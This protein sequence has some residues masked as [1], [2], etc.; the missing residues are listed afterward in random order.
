MSFVCAKETQNIKINYN[1]IFTCNKGI[2][3][4]TC[5]PWMFYARTDRVYEGCN[6]QQETHTCK[7]FL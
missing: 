4:K 3:N 7:V 2:A 5:H 1:D 6:I